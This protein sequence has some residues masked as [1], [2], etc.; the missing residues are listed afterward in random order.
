MHAYQKVYI[1][2]YVLI[3]CLCFIE[4]AEDERE[5]SYEEESENGPSHWGNIH[6][7]W[8]VC[9]NGSMQSPIDLLNERVQIVSQLGK[10][11]MN[12]QPSNATI[13]NRGHDIMVNKYQNN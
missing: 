12:Y 5:F 2:I 1:I 6:P 4:S 10:L 13:R 8:S 9:N 11:Q 3:C 7:E